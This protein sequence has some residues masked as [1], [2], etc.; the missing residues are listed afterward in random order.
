MEEQFE[1]FTGF[2]WDKGNNDKNLERHKVHNWE[3]EQIFLINL[4]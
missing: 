4:C 1:K 2:Q 3:C